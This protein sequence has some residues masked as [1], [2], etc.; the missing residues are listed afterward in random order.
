MP[1]RSGSGRGDG[2]GSRSWVV[3][4]PRLVW[5]HQRGRLDRCSFELDGCSPWQVFVVAWFLYAL[6]EEIRAAQTRVVSAV[7]R[8]LVPPTQSVVWPTG[9]CRLCLLPMWGSL[10]DV[11]LGCQG[12]RD[13]FYLARLLA[14]LPA[15]G[16]CAELVVGGRLAETGT[17]D[18]AI[19]H[20][21]PPTSYRTISEPCCTKNQEIISGNQEAPGGTLDHP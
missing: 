14:G 20:K 17:T 3:P 1:C 9:C 12:N 5:A 8:V 16:S 13:G 2:P 10:P 6:C 11:R 15:T 7:Q 18:C 19:R 21:G 4:E